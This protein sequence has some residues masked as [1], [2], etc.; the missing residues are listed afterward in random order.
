[1]K[2]LRKKSD[3]IISLRQ[4]C[5]NEF[6]TLPDPCLF[7]CIAHKKFMRL[8]HLQGKNK[9]LD[10]HADSL[11]D[12]SVVLESYLSDMIDESPNFSSSDTET[13]VRFAGFV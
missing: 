1:M 6:T 13:I 12:K 3:R 10:I 2:V 11:S 7:F 5:Y 8:L 9:K 4:L